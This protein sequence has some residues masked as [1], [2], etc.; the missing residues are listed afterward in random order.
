MRLMRTDFIDPS[1]FTANFF[2]TQV[3]V[4]A[5]EEPLHSV[6]PGAA[7]LPD[8]FHNACH[9]EAKVLRVEKFKRAANIGAVVIRDS[10]KIT[11]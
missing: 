5:Y 11:T 9:S 8:N 10:E 3:I 6:S 7:C 1:S 2:D 4:N